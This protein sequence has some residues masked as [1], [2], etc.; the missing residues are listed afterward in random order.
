MH[1]QAFS[2]VYCCF[3]LGRALVRNYPQQR[4]LSYN[5]DYSVIYLDEVVVSFW[6]SQLSDRLS[7][8]Y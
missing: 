1:L 4:K 8:H 2:C 6:G 7:A 5:D 3:C